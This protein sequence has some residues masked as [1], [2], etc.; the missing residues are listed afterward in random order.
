MIYALSLT[1]GIDDFSLFSLTLLD[2]AETSQYSVKH[3]KMNA[4]ALESY[5]QN[6]FPICETL[7]NIAQSQSHQ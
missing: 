5:S 2:T 6:Y 3:R 7:A 4:Q 1:G